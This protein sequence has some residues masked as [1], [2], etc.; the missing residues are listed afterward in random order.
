MNCTF[1]LDG[2]VNQITLRGAI[3]ETETMQ[4]SIQPISQD[5]LFERD[6]IPSANELGCN[7]MRVFVWV[8]KNSENE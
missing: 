2:A 4:K 6:D 5:P 1:F 7:E 3:F 8:S